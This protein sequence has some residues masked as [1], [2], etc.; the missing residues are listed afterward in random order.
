MEKRKV[1]LTNKK[2]GKMTDTEHVGLE[3]LTIKEA[4]R[5]LLMSVGT[6][7]GHMDA[8]RIPFI[9]YTPR[10]KMYIRAADL[11]AFWKGHHGHERRAG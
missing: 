9:Q 4:A 5:Y 8:G 1:D 10:G 3:L 2:G 6:L 7:R 11:E